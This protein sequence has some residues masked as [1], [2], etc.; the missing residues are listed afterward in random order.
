MSVPI[1][2]EVNG[3]DGLPITNRPVSALRVAFAGG[4]IDRL[5]LRQALPV[6]AGIALGRG[7]E[8]D[9]AVVV[10]AVVP[11]DQSSRPAAG[12]RQIDEG[13]KRRVRAVLQC[14][15]QRLGVGKDVCKQR[16]WLPSPWIT[17]IP[18]QAWP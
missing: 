9:C 18:A 5:A 2:V 10:L 6:Q 4:L 17:Q 3:L 16:G 14:F 7:D 11:F 13:R 8:A 1:R 12:F 15:E